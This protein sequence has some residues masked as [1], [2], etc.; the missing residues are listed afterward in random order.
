M[1]CFP[2]PFNDGPV[3]MIRSVIGD[4]SKC[5]FFARFLVSLGLR[6]SEVPCL[7]IITEIVTSLLSEAWPLTIFLRYA[8]IEITAPRFAQDPC[9]TNGNNAALSLY[10]Q[11]YKHSFYSGQKCTIW[12][13]F[14]LVWFDRV[15]WK[16]RN[17]AIILFVF[18]WSFCWHF[19]SGVFWKR[20]IF[21]T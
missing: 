10:Q 13:V 4:V 15:D 3:L 19:V 11:R 5:V 8:S 16:E 18:V 9:Q 1:K 12:V 20:E 14:V 6:K 2:I 7:H 21:S 17:T